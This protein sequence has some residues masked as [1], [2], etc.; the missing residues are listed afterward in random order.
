MGVD[1]AVGGGGGGGVGVVAA[2]VVAEEA[3]ALASG[4][5][6]V[7]ADRVSD[8]PSRTRSRGWQ[9]IRLYFMLINHK[10]A[11]FGPFS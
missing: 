6:L 7:E 4:D 5:F 8:A 1:G 9:D 3:E 2:E 11:S 10:D